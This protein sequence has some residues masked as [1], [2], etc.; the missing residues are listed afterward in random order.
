MRFKS[1]RTIPGKSKKIFKLFFRLFILLTF[2]LIITGTARSV[3][4]LLN[5]G[6]EAVRT[7][8]SNVLKMEVELEKLSVTYPNI[9]SLHNLSIKKRNTSLFKSKQIDC[10]FTW[11]ILQGK[12]QLQDIAFAD[13]YMNINR[14][15]DTFNFSRAALSKFI[16]KFSNNTSQSVYTLD[17]TK[18][19]VAFTLKTIRFQNSTIHLVD[20]RKEIPSLNGIFDIDLTFSD[21]FNSIYP[22]HGTIIIKKSTFAHNGLSGSVQG[23]VDLVK[24]LASPSLSINLP[25]DNSIKLHGAI[26][27]YLTNPVCKF[28]L[29]GYQIDFSFFDSLRFPFMPHHT[30]L[31]IAGEMAFTDPKIYDKASSSLTGN[32]SFEGGRW[33]VEPI[34][35]E[36][37]DNG[38][39]ISGSF[40]LDAAVSDPLRSWD[41]NLRDYGKIHLVFN[42]SSL[43]VN[44]FLETLHTYADKIV[45]TELQSMKVELGIHNKQGKLYIASAS[46]DSDHGAMI[47][48]GNMNPQLT[49]MEMSGTYIIPK[50]LTSITRKKAPSSINVQ[51]NE[52]IVPLQIKGSLLN[53]EISSPKIIQ[54]RDIKKTS[55]RKSKNRKIIKP[56][57]RKKIIL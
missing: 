22:Q 2:I 23:S 28:S 34:N 29:D 38:G 52:I 44:P 55:K 8:L 10:R 21:K 39:M 57:K 3:F 17:P 15:K 9:I 51:N 7:R 18:W 33:Q 48:E 49:D 13:A 41:K 19:P 6:S 14:Q 26:R 24:N 16:E 37:P 40:I 32:F 20:D 30:N 54:N 36:L 25:P 31:E 53:P 27:D 47:V 50:A 11:K 56:H 35:I 4:L 46:I 42:G 5:N 12:I 43:S 1:K 45:T